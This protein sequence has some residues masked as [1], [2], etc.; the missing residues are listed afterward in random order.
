M[1][2][3]RSKKYLQV[4]TL[5]FLF[6]FVFHLFSKNRIEAAVYQEEMDHSGGF[7]I[8]AEK[9]EGSMDLLGALLGKIEIGTGQIEGL[10]IFKSLPYEHGV[11]IDITIRSPGPVLVEN[12]ESETLGGSLPEFTGLCLPSRTDWLCLENVT[13]VVPW[14]MV[15]KI[16]LPQASITTC[17]ANQCPQERTFSI[18]NTDIEA[19]KRLIDELVRLIENEPEKKQLIQFFIIEEREHVTSIDDLLMRLIQYLNEDEENSSEPEE[20]QNIEES[21]ESMKNVEDLTHAGDDGEPVDDHAD[22][23]NGNENREEEDS[24]E[25]E[26]VEEEFKDANDVLLPI[27]RTLS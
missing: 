23:S 25:N 8:N 20:V 11:N 9:V 5:L 22:I 6:A 15:E 27:H 12:L 17:F 4:L 26:E 10:E 1:N 24:G 16:N 21:S 13:M 19:R 7:I 2:R 18:Q 14:Q 3:L